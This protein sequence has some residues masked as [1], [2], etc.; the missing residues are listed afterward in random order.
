MPHST[1]NP[2]QV[3]GVAPDAPD[4]ALRTAYHQRLR[5]DGATAELNAAWAQ[6]RDPTARERHRWTD[7]TMVLALPPAVERQSIPPNLEAI[8]QELASASD[9]ELGATE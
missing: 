2:Y 9:W 3:L 4:E 8:V 5:R 1:T 6:V 7:P